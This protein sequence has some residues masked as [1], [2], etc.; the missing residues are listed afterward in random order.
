MKGN[1]NQYPKGIGLEKNFRKNLWEKKK[2]QLIFLIV[3]YISHKSDLLTI[4]PKEP[5]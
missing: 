2:K 4:S 5:R 1:V 3:F